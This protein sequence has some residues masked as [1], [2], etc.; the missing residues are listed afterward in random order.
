MGLDKQ[1]FKYCKYLFIFLELF[2]NKLDENNARISFLF[3]IIYLNN[4]LVVILL[5]DKSI[6]FISGK[7]SKF[8]SL[9]LYILLLE[10]YIYFKE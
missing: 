7:K 6:A 5:H 3:L 4:F 9:K 2:K 8:C 1:D 10:K